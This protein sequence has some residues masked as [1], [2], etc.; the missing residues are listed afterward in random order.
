MPTLNQPSL[1][2]MPGRVVLKLVPRFTEKNGIAFDNRYQYQPYIGT[3]IAFGAP[4]DEEDAKLI[5][6]AKERTA[7]GHR[8]A[9]TWGS[10]T[11]YST[12]QMI[13]F[14]SDIHKD[15]FGRAKPRFEWLASLRVFR[16]KDLAASIAGGDELGG[17]DV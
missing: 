14:P 3:I 1:E 17:S 15:E 6:E 16:I 8:F 11:D 12:P 7:A 2:P 10:G 4:L 9:F 5:A 13:E